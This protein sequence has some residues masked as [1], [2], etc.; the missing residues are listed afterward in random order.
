[1]RYDLNVP[2]VEK[3]QAKQLGA[4][5]DQFRKTWY[6]EAMTDEL[7]RWYSGPTDTLPPPPEEYKDSAGNKY[8]T[9]PQV[10]L[11]IANALTAQVFT[12]LLVVGEVTNYGG[13]T[14]GSNCY[15]SIK[16]SNN[17]SLLNC[18]M[19][20]SIIP[21]NYVFKAGNKV[22][23]KGDFRYYSPNGSAKL[24]VKRIEDAG[25]GE[26]A[27]KK[28]ELRLKLE[29]EGLFDPARKKAIP[30]HPNL[31]GIITSK[32]GKAIRDI[33][34]I[35][36]SRNPYIRRVL[37]HVNVQGQHAVPSILNAIKVMDN[38][39][40]DVLIIGRGG[41]SDEELK[42]YD[43][44]SI[45]RA[46]AQART[47]IISAVGHEG[48]EPILNYVADLIASTPS[49]AAALAVPDIMTEVNK[50]IFL[51]RELG[52]NMRNL[53]LRRQESLRAL[54]AV[55]EKNAPETRLKEK[56]QNLTKLSDNLR[57]LMTTRFNDKVTRYKLLATELNGL[58][59]TAKL[60]NGFGYIS[61]GDKPVTSITQIQPGD[62]INIK[63]HDG[64]LEATVNKIIGGNNNG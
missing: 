19:S 37:Y 54:Y 10:N 43:D 25:E 42:A 63:I 59:P 58:S 60:I 22:L 3:D 38:Y 41:G 50:V 8:L 9:V 15:F 51:K 48:N 47:P 52:T 23:L 61:K 46:V 34:K 55:M 31:I 26:A 13:N 17:T 6:C 32:D 29:G 39:G 4:R 14:S 27:R 7:R 53:V 28:L 44:E 11:L 56:T 5:W 1:M 64:D 20:T 33:E 35:S 40:C 57:Q 2:F 30:K 21:R 49:D 18:M 12:D 36:T 45:V 62:S 16:D 24:I